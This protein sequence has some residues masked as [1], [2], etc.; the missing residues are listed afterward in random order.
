MKE[1][2]SAGPLL[3][4]LLINIAKGFPLYYDTGHRTKV[5]IA[6]VLWAVTFNFRR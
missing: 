5:A 6:S 2:V 3:I 4:E 1:G